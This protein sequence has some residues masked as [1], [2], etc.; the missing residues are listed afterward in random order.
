VQEHPPT[1]EQIAEYKNSR[2]KPNFNLE[3]YP[4]ALVVESVIYPEVETSELEAW[5]SGDDWTGG[6]FLELFSACVSINSQS[7][8]LNLGK[9]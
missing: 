2:D 7:N 8:V 4:L 9:G 6:E 1:D 5:L 3:T